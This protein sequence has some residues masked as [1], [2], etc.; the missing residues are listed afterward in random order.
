MLGLILLPIFVNDILHRGSRDLG[1][2]L[3]SMGR[4]ALIGTLALAG[5]RTTRGLSNVVMAGAAGLGVS[6][7]LLAVSRGFLLS[8]AIMVLLGFS[9][10]RHMASTNTLIQ[11]LIPDEYRGR[12]MSMYTMTVVG[13]GPFGSIVSGAVAHRVGTPM[14]VA[15]GGVI[16]FAGAM[17]FRARIEVFR[18]SAR[19]ARP[20]S[21]RQ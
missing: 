17:L 4:G 3:A 2:L 19:S 11:S 16:C 13:L 18:Q 5:R 20:R 1:I 15:A 7:V 8:N 21:A 12:I 6:L 9:T 10:L 14:T